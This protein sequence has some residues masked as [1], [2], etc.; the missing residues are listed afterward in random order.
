MAISSDLIRGHLESVILTLIKEKDRYAYEIASEIKTRTQGT[1]AM[2]E[3]TLYAMVQRLEK[4][5]IITSYIGDKSHG[6][7]RRYYQITS[8]GE[9]YLKTKKDEW[10]DL[11]AIM[12]RLLED[13]YESDR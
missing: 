2:K 4:R 1:F 5:G 11:K 3:A 9:A 10:R 6:K 12:A 7:K 13:T 8:L